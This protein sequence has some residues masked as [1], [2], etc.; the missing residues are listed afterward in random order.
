LEAVNRPESGLRK[1]TVG[2]ADI[3]VGVASVV[4][5]LRQQAEFKS[6]IKLGVI[7]EVPLYPY[8]NQ[9]HKELAPKLAKMLRQLKKED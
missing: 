4:D 3:Y 9:R 6:I 2:R 5:I 8:L 1:L 7:Q